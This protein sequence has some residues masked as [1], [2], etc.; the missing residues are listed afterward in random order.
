[1]LCFFLLIHFFRCYSTDIV[2][3][4]S[5]AESICS[6]DYSP[7]STSSINVLSKHRPKN[8][9]QSSVDFEGNQKPAIYRNRGQ[10]S[11]CES[12]SVESD[13]DDITNSTAQLRIEFNH[14]PLK[15]QL[16]KRCGQTD[17]LAFDEVYSAR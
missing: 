7:K 8:R 5:D 10:L 16:L 2:L 9:L 6:S 13:L 3:V 17:V 12:S 14:D 15:A 4:D 11:L 1:M